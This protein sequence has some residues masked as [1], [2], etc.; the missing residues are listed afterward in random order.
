MTPNDTIVFDVAEVVGKRAW[1]EATEAT[2]RGARDLAVQLL[3]GAKRRQVTAGR[4]A[5]GKPLPPRKH[6]RHDRAAGPP[7]APHRE[8]SRSLLR[9]RH[10]KTGPSVIVIWWG[11]GW[12]KVLGYHARGLVRHA[13]IR[14]VIDFTPD[15]MTRLRRQVRQWWDAN[16]G[17]HG[18]PPVQRPRP[19]KPTA[20]GPKPAPGPILPGRPIAE[21][22]AGYKEG[23]RKLAKI[24][25]AD[26]ERRKAESKLVAERMK[27]QKE[28]G[29]ITDRQAALFAEQGGAN[30]TPEV[31]AKFKAL[32]AEINPLLHRKVEIAAALRDSAAAT[33]DRVLGHLET[34]EPVRIESLPRPAHL[35]MLTADTHNAVEEARR[36]V[37]RVLRRG[38]EPDLPVAFGQIPPEREQRAHYGLGYR[39]V[40]LKHDESPSTAVHELG[41]AI[42]EQVTAGGVKVRRRSLEFLAHRVGTEPPRKLNDVFPAQSYRDDEEG[43]K[44]RFDE[45]FPG[46]SAYYV[47]KD[48]GRGATE[49]MSMGLQ[50]LHEDP[51]GFAEKDPEFCKFVLGILDGSL[52]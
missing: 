42:D 12:G 37:G 5:D 32:A 10:S 20:A 2:R 23:D 52:R 28:V 8:R 17:G 22:I 7:L 21:R 47:G 35:R 24:L 41:H 49:I 15:A 50:K 19:P 29:R 3:I 13:P 51:V 45:A 6:P 1:A 33:R 34:A 46:S 11:A 31:E 25:K 43:R 36:F 40:A 16:A 38:D 44:D 9:L 48:Y 4:G 30:F 26:V 39:Y 18:L 27:I 14:N